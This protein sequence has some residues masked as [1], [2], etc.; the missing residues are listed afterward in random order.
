[1][2]DANDE[3]SKSLSAETLRGEIAHIMSTIL[4]QS[5]MSREVVATNMSAILGRKFSKHIL[6]AYASKSRQDHIPPLDVAIA[7]DTVT[8]QNGLCK[9]FANKLS[10]K[11]LAN[12][13]IPIYALGEVT[14]EKEQLFQRE[15]NIKIVCGINESELNKQV[16]IELLEEESNTYQIILAWLIANCG[17]DSGVKFLSSQANELEST[18]S[19]KRKYKHAIATLDSVR[20]LAIEMVKIQKENSR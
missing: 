11:F 7:F 4:E 3:D 10:G 9:Y 2:L 15:K 6:D 12:E 5:N 20:E 16:S 14:K 19:S 1:M 17:S 18:D 13:E 8:K